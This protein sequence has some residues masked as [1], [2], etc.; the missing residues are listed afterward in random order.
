MSEERYIWPA[1]FL[2]SGVFASRF[3]PTQ[4][5]PLGPPHKGLL[6]AT[7]LISQHGY[8]GRRY[9]AV[10]EDGYI[11]GVTRILKQPGPPVLVVNGL[12]LPPEL[13]VLHGSGHDL[14][15]VLSDLGYDVWL[16]GQ[17]G[18]IGSDKHLKLNISDPEYWNF[19]FDEPGYYD[20]P[21]MIDLI[22]GETGHSSLF[23]VGASLGGTFFM[24]MC[25]ERPEYCAAV[26][27][28]VQFAPAIWIPQWEQ[29][30]HIT[31]FNLGAINMVV[32]A[33][34]EMSVY[35]LMMR[36]RL[37]TETM[38][39][40]CGSS[41][42]ED[43]CFMCLNFLTGFHKENMAEGWLGTTLAF[44]ASG[45][46]TKQLKHLVQLTEKGGARKYDWGIIKNMMK[47]GSVK[48]PNYNLTK[49]T[50][51]TIVYYS[52]FDKLLS[53]EAMEE[54]INLIG[55]LKYAKPSPDNYGHAELIFGKDL[56]KL[57]HSEIVDFFDSISGLD[58]SEITSL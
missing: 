9:E 18:M 54:G 32:D 5:R 33:S 23:Y 25:S 40:F 28:N 15:F 11:L 4:V 19:S 43:P 51:P 2:L 50:S 12:G 16:G 17:R 44:T 26:A 36:P 24:A 53:H 46:S 20:L 6:N 52:K 1:L 42:G 45:T 41:L 48:P 31:R 34:N 49:I 14:A 56:Y 55:N 13:W 10:T 57:F 39:E 47:Y 8:E 3:D 38:L 27:G 22:L 21:A 29:L 7:E 37:Y 58:S 30:A 35:N